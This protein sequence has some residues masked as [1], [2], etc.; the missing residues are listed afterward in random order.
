MTHLSEDEADSFRIA[1]STTDYSSAESILMSSTAKHTLYCQKWL[2]LV[3]KNARIAKSRKQ[4]ATEHWFINL[5]I[6]DML[7]TKNSGIKRKYCVNP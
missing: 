2:N 3:V 4:R 7:V 1:R 5:T 6:N